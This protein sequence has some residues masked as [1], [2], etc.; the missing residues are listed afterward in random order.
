MATAPSPA[1]KLVSKVTSTDYVGGD[2][3]IISSWHVWRSSGRVVLANVVGV[4]F[5]F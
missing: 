4:L 2:E 5:H 1:T 3:R